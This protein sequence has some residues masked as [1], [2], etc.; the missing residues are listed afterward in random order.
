[1]CYGART[2]KYTQDHVEKL[3]GIDFKEAFGYRFLHEFNRLT[4]SEYHKI[5]ITAY[6][7]AV[8]INTR[9]GDIRVETEEHIEIKRLK[10]DPLQRELEMVN[11]AINELDI[12]YSKHYPKKKVAAVLDHERQ[13]EG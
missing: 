6:T 7:G 3:G 10:I 5:S 12:E 8:S 11:R 4:S 13:T 2:E 1:M 9:T